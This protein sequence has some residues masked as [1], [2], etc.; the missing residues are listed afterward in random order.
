M[1]FDV[2]GE[3]RALFYLIRVLGDFRIANLVKVRNMVESAMEIGHIY[4]AFHVGKV[5]VIDSSAIGLIMN[6]QRKLAIK[7]GSVYLIGIPS[8]IEPTLASTDIPR[9]IKC[10]TSLEEADR[11]IG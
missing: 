7:Q 9:V 2:Q 3:E 11:Q 6:I 4:I 10:F 8:T 1:G 5:T